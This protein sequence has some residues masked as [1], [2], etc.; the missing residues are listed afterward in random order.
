M[1]LLRERLHPVSATAVQGVVRQIQDLDSGRF[2]DRENASRA[3][4]ALGELAAPELEAALRNPV[5]AE[6]RR[7]IESILDKARAAAIPP[8]VLRAVRAVEVL[9]RI[10]TKEARAILASL[11]QGV[12]NARLTR[13]AKASLARIDRA[14]QQRGN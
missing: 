4:E 3:L 9:D 2:A 11:A 10:G 12:P 8:N 13:E 1:P 14:S 5:S 7:R 6:V